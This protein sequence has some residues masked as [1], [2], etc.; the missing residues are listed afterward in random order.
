[1]IGGFISGP[2]TTVVVRAIGPSLTQIGVQNALM[3]PTLELRDSNGVLVR[4]NN[5]W[6][7]TQQAQI[8]AT[9]LAPTNEH[10]SAL[11]QVLTSGNDTAIVRGKNNTAG[12]GL[13]EVYNVK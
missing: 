13:V 4:S 10:E 11:I 5:D 7:E 2:N 6:Q 9:G 12:V 8:Q 3:D 1:M